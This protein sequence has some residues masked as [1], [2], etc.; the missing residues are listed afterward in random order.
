MGLVR[1]TQP[2]WA[3]ASSINVSVATGLEGRAL[4][5]ELQP[6]SEDFYITGFDVTYQMTFASGFAVD[7]EIAAIMRGRVIAGIGRVG[8]DAYRG[9]S[10]YQFWRQ[11]DAARRLGDNVPG[12]EL[13]PSFDGWVPYARPTLTHRFVSPVRVTT[14][15]LFTLMA[16]GLYNYNGVGDAEKCPHTTIAVALYGHPVAGRN[17]IPVELR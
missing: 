16:G 9:F 10:S 5:F 13:E 14:G 12:T 17:T 7:A 1:R 8:E 2:G 15:S 3:Q 11:G 4:G 6:Q